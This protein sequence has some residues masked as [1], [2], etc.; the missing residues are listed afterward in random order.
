[1]QDLLY[2]SKR[3]VPLKWVYP[4]FLDHKVFDKNHTPTDY[5]AQY[6]GT[7]NRH[8][9]VQYIL[10][11]LKEGKIKMKIRDTLIRPINSEEVAQREKSGIKFLSNLGVYESN[12]Q[13][14]KIY[15]SLNSEQGADDI[16]KLGH[17]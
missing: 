14:Y 11:L 8:K 6:I 4:T 5:F 9:F 12:H 7:E 2:N 10:T 17:Q 13:V 1:M 16:K 3:S 15:N